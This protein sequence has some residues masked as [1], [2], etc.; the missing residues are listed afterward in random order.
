MPGAVLAAG[1]FDGSVGV[2]LALPDGD[3]DLQLIDDETAGVEGGIAMGG[4]NR[5]HDRDVTDLQLPDSVDTGRRVDSEALTSL[6]ED[7]A[8]LS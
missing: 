1:P 4:G 5:D 8:A 6:R 7:P 2:G 3:P